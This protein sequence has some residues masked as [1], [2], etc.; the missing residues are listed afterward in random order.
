MG[1]RLTDND[2]FAGGIAAYAMVQSLLRRLEEAGTPQ[3]VIRDIIEDAARSLEL[4][5]RQMRPKHPAMNGAILLL[6]GSAGER[7]GPEGLARPADAEAL[8]LSNGL[9]AVLAVKSDNLKDS[10]KN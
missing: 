4:V 10:E 3:V 5:S 8:N 1:K 7:Q 9:S 2:A 6:R